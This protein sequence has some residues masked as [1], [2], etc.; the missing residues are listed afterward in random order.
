MSSAVAVASLLLLLALVIG[1]RVHSLGTHRSAKKLR[2]AVILGARVYEDG[3]PS[4]ALVD[5][6]ALGVQLINEG[7]VERLLLTGG[8][9]DSR[10]TEAAV[11]ARLARER[12]LTDAQLVLEPKSRS[13]FENALHCAA[14]LRAENDL[15]VLLVTC[16]FHVARAAAQFR[17][18]ALTVWPVPS[19]RV[20]DASTRLMVTTKEVIGF[21]RR[22]WLLARLR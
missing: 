4:D 15:E 10:P 12:G 1:F 21:L 5:R 7:Q 14:I 13:T 8:T 11:M 22:P 19:K 2:T 17:A 16:D 18:H 20:L 3:R 6:L 9:N